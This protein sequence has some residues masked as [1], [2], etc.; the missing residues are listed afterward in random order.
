MRQLSGRIFFRNGTFSLQKFKPKR[1]KRTVSSNSRSAELKF[2]R[3]HV[4]E[5]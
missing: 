5:V 3:V 4:N 1:L 2:A